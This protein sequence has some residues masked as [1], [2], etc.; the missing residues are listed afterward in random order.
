M[1]T[2]TKSQDRVSKTDCKLV[3]LTHSKK[4][5]LTLLTA[6]ICVCT[7]ATSLVGDLVELTSTKGT[8]E[9]I[10]NEVIPADGQLRT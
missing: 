7:Q 1:V 2:T 8:E 9:K 6:F 3:N 10:E 4:L 5:N